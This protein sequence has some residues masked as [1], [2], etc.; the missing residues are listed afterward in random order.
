MTDVNIF[1]NSSYNQETQHNSK[2]LG[3]LPMPS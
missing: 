1:L 2:Q 3:Q